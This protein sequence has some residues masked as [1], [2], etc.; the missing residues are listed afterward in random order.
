MPDLIS[1]AGNAVKTN[2]AALAV[3]GNNIANVNTDGYVRQELD[4]RENLPTKVGTTS[5]GS[6][7]LATGV[8]RAY[9]S[10]VESSLRSSFSDLRSQAPIIDLTNR[11]I[12]ILGDDKASLSPAL[13]DFFSSFRDLGLD[14]SSQLRR[15][16]ALSEAEGLVSRFNE[17]GAQLSSLDLDSKGALE[18]RVAEF[19][20]LVSQLSVVNT[21]LGRQS[22]LEAQPADLLNT[23]DLLLQDI[24]GLMKIGVKEQAN[25][26]VTVTIGAGIDGIELV[27]KGSAKKLGLEF[28]SNSIPSSVQLI[29]DP[30]GSPQN[31]SGIS[32]GEIGGYISFRELTLKPSFDQVNTLAAKFSTSVNDALAKGMDLY[33]SKGTPLFEIKPTILV[34]SSFTK[35]K[36][37]I[38]ADISSSADAKKNEL[39]MI[40]DKPNKRWLVTDLVTNK[41]FA[42]SNVN[43]FSVNGIS[44]SVSGQP[45][46]GDVF[47]IRALDS[48]ASNIKVAISDSKRLAAGE[49]FGITL[50]SGNT[51]GAKGA[52]AA[53]ASASGVKGVNFQSLLVNN[54]HESSSKTIKASILTPTFTIPTGTTDLDLSVLR[55]ADSSAEFQVFTREGVHLFGTGSLSETNLSAMLTSKNGFESTAIYNKSYLNQSNVYLNKD[56]SLGASGKSL[57]VTSST[58]QKELKTEASILGNSI[59][60]TVNSTSASKTLI[61]ANSLSLNGVALTALSLA[62]TQVETVTVGTLTNYSG[63]TV[64][65]DGTTTVTVANGSAPANVAAVV[66]GIQGGTGYGSLNFTVAAASNGTDIEY[67][68]KTSGVKSG[69]VFTQAGASN[70]AIATTTSTTLTAAAVVGWLNTNISAN[71]LALTASAETLVTVPKSKIN[72]ASNAL[73]INGTTI[74]ISPLA[75]TISELANKINASTGTTGVVAGE[76]ANNRLTLKNIAGKE[77]NT[78]ALGASAG[79]LTV[80]GDVRASIKVEATRGSGDLTNKVVSLARNANGTSNELAVLGFTETLSLDGALDEDLIVFTTGATTQELGFYAGYTNSVVDSFYQRENTTDVKF[81]SATKYQIVDRK[82]STV[83]SERT[84]ALGSKINYGSISLTI[85][86]QPKAGDIFSVDGNKSGVASNE[87]AL[88]IADI[89][90]TRGFGNGQTIKESYLS[91]LTSAGSTSRRSA[92]AQQALDVVYQQAVSA[93]DSKAG[94]NL[95]EEAADLLRFQQA[96]QAAAKVMQMANQLFDSILRI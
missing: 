51:G 73:S 87:N 22:K 32:G 75:T 8:K 89:E 18:Y 49:L 21:K 17:I 23:R 15:E 61:A 34:D 95:D 76:D 47:S 48:E 45:V 72:F 56:W 36:I 29:L 54:L 67:T 70:E 82:T 44:V 6:G 13:D 52:V 41:T 3:V 63:N 39:R 79:V 14:P 11:V 20:S 68:W 78:I 93:K 84:W 12:D 38:T 27:T 81:T 94:V 35:S 43:H 58:D 28:S 9:D 46:A 33:G 80:T 19:N 4:I 57:I 96:Y 50:G 42:A 55:A 71:S 92:I 25:G 53:V 86:G 2:Q 69:A 64:V 31:L 7:A 90:N 16:V 37:A 1:I 83:I 10:L 60:A 65:S 91:I 5:I 77:S 74:S 40:F 85:D 88:R 24:A 66:S 62:A 26:E 59:P 30:N